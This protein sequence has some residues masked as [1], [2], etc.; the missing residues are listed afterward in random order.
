MVKLV[1]TCWYFIF[2]CWANDDE[3]PR[4]DGLRGRL[5]AL[6]KLFDEPCLQP[7][8]LNEQ[9]IFNEQ[10]K[11]LFY[12]CIHIGNPLIK[13]YPYIFF[14][15]DQQ[16]YKKTAN[17]L[18]WFTICSEEDHWYQELICIISYAFEFLIRDGNECSVEALIG[19]IDYVKTDRRNRITYDNLLKQLFI[20]RNGPHPLLSKSIRLQALKRIPTKP[21]FITQG[22]VFTESTSSTTYSNKLKAL[23]MTNTYCFS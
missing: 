12:K 20:R 7:L 13:T 6:N 11:T 22:S 8:T 16:K 10:Y 2:V 3:L 1:E 9:A 23:K 4:E 21:T 17:N 14:E 19:D 5:E 15:N 18:I